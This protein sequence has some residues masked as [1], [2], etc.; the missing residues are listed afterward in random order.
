[1]QRELD[2]LISKLGTMTVA[3][4]HEDYKYLVS[5]ADR[6]GS[7]LRVFELLRNKR[8]PPGNVAPLLFTFA[9]KLSGESDEGLIAKIVDFVRGC[10]GDSRETSEWM[11]KIL[12]LVLEKVKDKRKD[13]EVRLR[14]LECIRAY[15]EDTSLV[16]H[17][18]DL[19]CTKNSA[20]VVGSIL[21][22]VPSICD[23]VVRCAMQQDN[24]TM[25]R[26][27]SGVLPGVS[28]RNV[29]LFVNYERFGELLDSEHF[30]MRSC[31]LEICGNVAEHFKAKGMVEEL[32][33][34]VGVVVERLSDTY[35]LVRYKA[36]QVLECLF[37]RGLVTVGKRHEIIRE[38]SG[39]VLDKAAV[40]RR[41]AVTICS[42]L[43]M[44]HPFASEK[45]L[46]RRSLGPGRGKSERGEEEDEG[47]RRKYYEDLN[48]FHDIMK[49]TQANVATLLRVGAKTEVSECIEFMKLALHYQIDGSGEAFESLFGLV[50]TRDAEPLV[51]S[52]RDLLMQVR[53]RGASVFGFLKGFIRPEG[54]HSFERVLGELSARRY[55]DK[56]FVVELC[57]VFL[58]GE[59]LAETSYLLRHIGRPLPVETF[60]SLLLLCTRLLFCSQE[61]KGVVSMLSVYK[62]VMQIR[63][64]ERVAF[65]EEIV[66]TLVKN[67]SKMVFFEHSTVELTVSAIY[68]VSREPE[69]SAVMLLERLCRAEK[70]FL[71]VVSAVGCVGL[72]HMRYVE[73]LEELVKSNR[74]RVKVDRAVITP[75]MTERRRSIN[76]SRLSISTMADEDRSG[77]TMLEEPG[78]G[79]DV[80]SKLEDRSE[81]EIVDFFFYIKEREMLYGK[82]SVLCALKRVVEEACCAGDEE[83]QAAGHVS[84]YKLMCISSEFF[85]EH[86]EAFIRSMGHSSARIR[87]NAV[88]AMSDFLMNYNTTAEKHA[89]LLL[90]SLNDPSADVRKNALLVIHSLVIKNILKIKGHGCRLVRLL[91]DEDMEIR[92]MAEHLLIQ[93]SR[94]DAMMAALFY[95]VV[96]AR[97]GL[98]ALAIDFLAD[99]INEKTK[100]GLFLK[101][102]RSRADV[103]TLRLLHTTFGLDE[104]LLDG[105][106]VSCE[107]K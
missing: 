74:M 36:L 26:N 52:L 55:I 31:F 60:R 8:N 23:E 35:F 18:M 48:E 51:M 59:E 96:T 107:S 67:L 11:I 71:K 10:R 106:D 34:V 44:A 70:G 77:S 33:D 3:D 91:A 9:S 38:V 93:I 27:L 58:Q 57:N 19:M 21:E 32:N 53:A 15:G 103:E 88:V 72:R 75:E 45:T 50:W 76:A 64:R 87:A 56:G 69:K 37:Q 25:L 105:L 63:I 43:L 49:E 62:N 66:E 102:L 104:K 6:C 16:S 42:G 20:D 28:E 54:N 94:K 84:L 101:A 30:F 4:G 99:L 2:V 12:F 22:F 92:E 86:Y 5:C 90:E 89:H 83:T 17:V 97:D 40:V 47:C 68:S 61:E 13:A 73:G 41:K 78:T 29:G 24:A 7:K 100:E 1:M 39:R 82:A 95:E 65:D 98:L 85:T 81:E 46:E 14:V 79:K 80:S